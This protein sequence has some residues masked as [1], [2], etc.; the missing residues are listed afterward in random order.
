MQRIH[1]EEVLIKL[2]DLSDL[3]R[4]HGGVATVVSNSD[5]VYADVVFANSKQYF[6]TSHRDGK[7]ARSFGAIETAVRALVSAGFP[8]VVVKHTDLEIL[9][10][11]IHA[12]DDE[13]I[14]WE[15][16]LDQMGIDAPI[17]ELIKH[18]D[19]APGEAPSLEFLSAYIEGYQRAL[20][21]QRG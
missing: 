12:D 2:A 19:N 21:I 6:R 16:K 9:P 18:R 4:M 1:M 3:T 14:R 20:H 7:T 11:W 10:E 15:S 8:E 17:E 13:V 5:G